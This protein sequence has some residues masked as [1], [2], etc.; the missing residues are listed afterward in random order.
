MFEQDYIMRLIK[1]L[2]RT[3]FKLLFQI[4]L[5]NPYTKLFK[6]TEQKNTL[7]NLLDL[8]D[9]GCINDAENQLYD[10]ITEQ[11]E[12]NSQDILKTALLFYA[13]LNEKSNDF[14][15]TNNFSREEVKQGLQYVIDQYSLHDISDTFLSED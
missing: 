3:L 12:D 11:T 7:Q 13:H 5:E 9:S 1:E 10:M 6:D 2:V 8:I 15:E 14:L 4:D